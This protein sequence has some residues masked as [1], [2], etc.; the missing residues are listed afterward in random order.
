V[1]TFRPMCAGRWCLFR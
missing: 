1:S